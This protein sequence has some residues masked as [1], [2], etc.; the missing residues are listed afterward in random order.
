MVINSDLLEQRKKISQHRP[1]FR[2]QESWRYKRLAENW[3]KPKGID[4]KMRLQVS[5]VPALVKIGY[6]GPKSSRGLHPSGYVDNLVYNVNDLLKLNKDRDA[7]RIAHTVGK[8]KRLEIISKAESIGIKVLNGKKPESNPSKSES[9]SL[10]Q[11]N[12]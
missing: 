7:A 5:G 12:N 10:K 6:R 9:I 1:K 4:N 3:R 8:K 2:R 11:E